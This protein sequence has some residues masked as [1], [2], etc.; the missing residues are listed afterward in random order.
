M[1][2]ANAVVIAVIRAFRGTDWMYIAHTIC[3]A[4]TRAFRWT[5]DGFFIA[6][7]A[8]ENITDIVICKTLIRTILMPHHPIAIVVTVRIEIQ[9]KIA[10]CLYSIHTGGCIFM[11]VTILPAGE[12]AGARCL[13]IWFDLVDHLGGCAVAP[14]DGAPCTLVA[15]RTVTAE[16]IFPSFGHLCLTIWIGEL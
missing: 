9:I 5:W 12:P 11:R 3:I 4:V 15:A 8:I 2:N 16:A 14:I 6:Y 1:F 10:I 7:Q 13:V